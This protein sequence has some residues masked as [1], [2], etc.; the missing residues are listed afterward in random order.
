MLR[1][2]SGIEIPEETREQLARLSLPLPGARWTDPDDMHLTLRFL[3]DVD[4]ETANDFADALDRIQVTRFT[5]QLDGLG[6]FGGREPRTIWAGV[7][8][9]EELNA[10]YR[11]HERAARTAGLPPE[12]RK[13]KPHVTI[14]RLRHSRPDAVANFLANKGAFRSAPFV[15]HEV[16]LFS[17]RPGTGGGPYVVEETF[18]LSAP[19]AP[20]TTV[21]C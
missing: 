17:A 12:G 15:V 21:H 13:F 6:A 18:P 19:M 14:A 16:A 9:N 20:S 4:A 2:F 8:P 5:L 3:G 1:L 11:A 10:L 7:T